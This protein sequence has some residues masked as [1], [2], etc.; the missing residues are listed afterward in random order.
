[1]KEKIIRV[2]KIEPKKPPVEAELK[3]ELSSLQEAVG[4]LI[5]FLP[6]D[7]SKG[8]ELM[9]N[10]EG[11]LIG[12][13]PNRRVG[14]DVIV[15]T[16]YVLKCNYEG[17][18]CSLT[19]ADIDEYKKRFANPEHISQEEAEATIFFGFEGF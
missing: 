13:E 10:E 12:L 8:I 4:G 9:C 3:N 1:M 6:L 5:E 15:G 2:L 7:S 17:E 19:E 18:C 11:K 16:F 14:S